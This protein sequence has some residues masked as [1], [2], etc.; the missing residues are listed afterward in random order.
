MNINVIISNPSFLKILTIS[1][2]FHVLNS[3]CLVSQTLAHSVHLAIFS[4][5]SI[6]YHVCVCVTIILLS[7]SLF[8]TL[9]KLMAR[10]FCLQRIWD[11]SHFCS[12]LFSK[13]YSMFIYFLA[14]HLVFSDSVCLFVTRQPI[15]QFI[16]HTF[17]LS[18]LY[19]KKSVSKCSFYLVC[20]IFLVMISDFLSHRKKIGM[21]KNGDSKLSHERN[22]C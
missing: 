21:T 22:K 15:I 20:Y 12:G 3:I 16:L 6:I 8:F 11:T 14:M 1:I 5:I 17:T 9:C 18:F 4:F 2:L 7:I 10:V 19:I 13:V